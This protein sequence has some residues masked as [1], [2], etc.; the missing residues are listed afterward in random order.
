MARI[1]AVMNQKGG[2][3]KTTT[4]VN[5][6]ACVAAKSRRVLAIDLDPQA[7]T[8]SGLGRQ[9]SEGKSV[10]DVLTGAVP[11]D[12]III[13]T[14]AESLRLAPSDI[15]LAAAEVELLGVDKK[16]HALE[17]AIK[18]TVGLF[19]YIIIDCPPSLGQLTLN[20]LTAADS[21]LIPIQCEY[22]ALEGVGQLMKTIQMV[23]RNLNPSL[24]IE[25]VVLTMLDG[26]TN[27]GLQVVQQVK[28]HFK[29][30][31][32]A[33]AIPRNIRLGEAPSHGLP[34]NIYDP[35]SAGAAAYQELAKEF[36][37]RCEGGNPK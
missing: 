35:R 10:Y 5:L 1:V 2:V 26:R 14:S 15:R 25:G 37:S 19:D 27:L 32:Y 33:S 29:S 24:E 18:P 36:I 20:A 28:K 9:A 16:E 7:N 13:D 6:S 21:V 11:L 4:V 23:K 34:V 22:F 30:K 17:K 12:A 3:G 31:V 8:T